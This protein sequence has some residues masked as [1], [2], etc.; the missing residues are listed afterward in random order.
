MVRGLLC[1]HCNSRVDTCPH[2]DG[3]PLGEI[4]RP[5]AGRCA[6]HSASAPE[7][8]AP[9][10]RQQ[11]RQ[12]GLGSFPVLKPPLLSCTVAMA[13]RSDRRVQLLFRTWCSRA[14]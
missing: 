13:P 3:C 7:Q 14:R 2:P 9:K 6:G 5:S 4:S 1:L 12:A 10:R 8:G 11:N